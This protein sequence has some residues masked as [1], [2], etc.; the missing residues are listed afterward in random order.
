MAR[1]IDDDFNTCIEVTYRADSGEF[2]TEKV[3]HKIIPASPWSPLALR[4]ES[5]A[6]VKWNDVLAYR[7]R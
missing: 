1:K 2:V 7:T 5:G 6:R 3:A 4:T